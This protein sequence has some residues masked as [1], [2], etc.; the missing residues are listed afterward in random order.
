MQHYE[1]LFI[2]SIEL[3]EQGQAAI[4]KKVSDYI[5]GEG[6]VISKHENWG[7]RKLAYEINHKANGFYVLIEFNLEADKLKKLDVK[8][9]LISEILRYLIIKKRVKTEAEVAKEK[10]IQEKVAAKRI[11]AEEKKGEVREEIKEE[12]PKKEEKIKSKDTKISLDDLDKK[13]DDIL[14]E[15]I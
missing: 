9:R 13:L 11:A 14:K 4:L 3:D 1:F 12:K 6:G 10:I 5:I 8:L 2:T 15:E 7:S